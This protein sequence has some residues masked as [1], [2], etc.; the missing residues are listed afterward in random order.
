M[1]QV[2]LSD[3]VPVISVPELSQIRDEVTI[4]DTREAEEYS[5]SRIPGSIHAGF[6]E[7]D[8]SMMDKIDKDSPIVVYCSVGYRSEKIGKKIA[9]YGF[10]DVRNLYGGIFE[11][12]NQHKPIVNKNGPVNK[13][14]PYSKIWSPWITNNEIIVT[15]SADS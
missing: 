12:V 5:V 15:Y 11:W 14:H 8:I 7:F 2:M 6:D 13:V 4:L 10:Q 9:D 1:L 3:S